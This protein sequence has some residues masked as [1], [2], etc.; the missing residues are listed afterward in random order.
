MRKT[1]A[2]LCLAAGACG[3]DPR[4]A[5]DSAAPPATDSAARAPASTRG[6][7]GI[8][9]VV[10]RWLARVDSSVFTRWGA[11]PFECCVYRDWV[12]ETPVI[13]R[14]RPDSS[15][16]V[17]AT[18]P[19]GARFEADTGF[20]RITS[21]QLVIVTDT[22]EAYRMSAAPDV[23]QPDTLAPG[24]TVL[25]LDYQGEGH[26][27]LTDGRVMYSAEQ[28]WPNPEDGWQPYGG[29][30][31]RVLGRH[32]AEW[33]AQVTTAEGTRGWIDAY[34]AELGNVDACGVPG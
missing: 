17:V 10:A 9:P 8:D 13:V 27:Y 3:D 24:D 29:A 28:F 7:A 4:P 25:V 6:A 5:D 15:A 11:C 34:G 32:A 22:V 18:L 33:W 21:P 26:H 19:I 2:L 16:A 23:G 30:R 14:A 20:V 12:A 1:L 31:G